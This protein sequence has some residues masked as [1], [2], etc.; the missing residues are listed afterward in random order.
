MFV[1]ETAASVEAPETDSEEA[2]TSA[3]AELPET[4]RLP[5]LIAPEAD[6]AEEEIVPRPLK[7]PE[8]TALSPDDTRLGIPPTS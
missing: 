6:I 2:L 7:S 4:E 5:P 1:A 3:R 8:R